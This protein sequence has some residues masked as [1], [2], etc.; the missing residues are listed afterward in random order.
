MESDPPLPTTSQG[1]IKNGVWF[2]FPLEQHM[3]RAWSSS[4]N[5]K[6]RIYVDDVIVAEGRS[7]R[8]TSK[9]SFSVG[10]RNYTIRF[11]AR[12][13]KGLTCELAEGDRV[14]KAYSVRFG[15]EKNVSFTSWMAIVFLAGAILAV[16][17]AITDWPF[18]IMFLVVL[19]VMQS[20]RG[21]RAK[22]DFWI[23][24]IPVTGSTA[25]AS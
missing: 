8:A 1:S 16:I 20:V 24:E 21:P 14:L 19:L 12:L 4:F 6:E 23:E 9:H 18:G 13:R 5:G 17:S 2:V 7:F 25:G 11:G 15:E 10:D 22:T 3:I